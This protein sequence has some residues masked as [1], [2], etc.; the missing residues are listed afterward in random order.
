MFQFPAFA[1]ARQAGQFLTLPVKGL[2]HSETRGLT[3]VC[4]SPRL[5][6]AYR[7]LPRL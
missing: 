6:A 4:P 7:V 5:I 1:T 2:P 3:G